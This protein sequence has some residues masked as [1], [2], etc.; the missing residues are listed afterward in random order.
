M[1]QNISTCTTYNVGPNYICNNHGACNGQGQCICNNGWTSRGDFQLGYYNDC[2]ISILFVQVGSIVLI[3]S[4]AIAFSIG[5]W[6][7]SHFK[8]LQMSTISR[9]NNMI[10]IFFLMA[11]AMG[12]IFGSCRFSD[13]V[14]NIVGADVGSSLGMSGFMV[15]TFAGWALLSV[16][17][18]DFLKNASRVFSEDSRNRV[19]DMDI[20]VRILW[21]RIALASLLIPIF[22][23]VANIKSQTADG[24]TICVLAVCIFEVEIIAGMLIVILG[25]FNAEF[26]KYVSSATTVQV[27]LSAIRFRT[28]ILYY[29]CA[30]FFLTVGPT[31]V[32]IAAIEYL[33]RKFTYFVILFMICC[34]Y[35][36]IGVL[37]MLSKSS[38]GNNSNHRGSTISTQNYHLKRKSEDN[39]SSIF[40]N[41]VDVHKVV[42]VDIEAPKVIYV[43]ADQTP[44]HVDD[45]VP[46]L[47]SSTDSDINENEPNNGEL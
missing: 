22:V 42:P 29:I 35:P 10:S 46:K 7:V 31:M 36:T 38:R 15:F 19:K 11:S 47:L 8:N 34:I 33:R 24:M 41:N 4:A 6:N 12:I 27:E 9:P 3:I 17:F 1:S 21:Y 20:T 37:I 14:G 44:V 16:I 45:E 26:A 40:A 23:I 2:D 5:I 43:E 32:V 13:P 39:R 18:G 28:Q 25:T 30:F